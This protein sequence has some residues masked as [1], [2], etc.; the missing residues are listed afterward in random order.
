MNENDVQD[1]RSRSQ[2]VLI[3]LIAPQSFNVSYY[4]KDNKR[5]I[6]RN[7]KK[8]ELQHFFHQALKNKEWNK[9]RTQL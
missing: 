5:T 4:Y 3:A 2:N 6:H 1:G 9:Q 8:K 7:K